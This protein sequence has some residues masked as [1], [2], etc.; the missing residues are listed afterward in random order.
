MFQAKTCVCLCHQWLHDIG[1]FREFHVGFRNNAWMDGEIDRIPHF[2]QSLAVAIIK[3]GDY[4]GWY[5]YGSVETWHQTN[6]P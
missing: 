4:Y 5:L 1:G 3:A 6:W 2:P